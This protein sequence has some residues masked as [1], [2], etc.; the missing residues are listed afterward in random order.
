M[1]SEQIFNELR[2]KQDRLVQPTPQADLIGDELSHNLDFYLPNEVPS[3]STTSKSPIRDDLSKINK[4]KLEKSRNAIATAENIHNSFS[5]H[6]NKSF[7]IC[8]SIVNK[9]KVS[10]LK[11]SISGKKS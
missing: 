9:S 5:D 10:N 4:F 1:H 8:Q 2:L 3:K 11:N 7:G 6:T